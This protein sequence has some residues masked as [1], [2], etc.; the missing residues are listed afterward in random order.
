MKLRTPSLRRFGVLFAAAGLLLLA[1][2]TARGALEKGRERPVGPGVKTYSLIDKEK[3]LA[4]YVVE[5]DLSDP[6][7]SLEVGLSHDRLTRNE[8]VPSM[9]KRLTKA[10]HRVIAAVNGDFWARAGVAT[11]MLVQNGQL[12]R[13]PGARSV[14][15]LTLDKRPIIDYFETR[16]S[17]IGTQGNALAV[18]QLNGW[19]EGNETILFTSNRVE[20]VT[21]PLG[22]YGVLLAPEVWELQPDDKL[23]A[24]VV[25]LVDPGEKMDLKET[26]FALIVP[27]EKLVS[28]PEGMVLGDSVVLE[29]DTHGRIYGDLPGPLQAVAGGPRL[30]L[31][32]K[33]VVDE[34]G[35]MRDSFNQTRH[36]R[37]AL[38]I[39]QDEKTL[40][41]VVVDGRQT[42]HSIGID[43]YDLA[44]FLKG[45]GSYQAMNLDGGGSSTMVVRDEIA[46]RPS[47]SAGPRPVTNC[48]M[49]VSNAPE[50][51]LRRLLIEPPQ[52]E[53]F[54][55]QTLQLTLSAYDEFYN[56][57]EI[58]EDIIH[59]SVAGG[60]AEIDR[61]GRLKAGKK[62]G[63]VTVVVSVEGQI[64]TNLNFVTT[65]AQGR[66]AHPQQLRL[67]PEQIRLS[68]GEATQLQVEALSLG[69]Q[70]LPAPTDSLRWR[71]KNRKIGTL[72]RQGRFIA[73]TEGQGEIQVRFS[74]LRATIPVLVGQKRTELLEDFSSVDDWWLTGTNVSIDQ[75]RIQVSSEQVA[76]GTRS[77][78][79]DYDLRHAGGTSAVYLN[80]DKPMPWTPEQIDFWLYGNDCDHLFRMVLKDVDGEKFYADA[81]GA[82][83]WSGEWKK[84]EIPFSKFLPLWSNPAAKLTAPFYLEQLYIVEPRTAEKS[85][86][87]IYIDDLTAVYPPQWD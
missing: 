71:L 6:H 68:P 59:W 5:V 20:S 58:P 24:T 66:I 15:A 74:G 81:P 25:R 70:W 48:L 1:A 50:G 7:L 19:A 17:V 79:L 60:K 82:I 54:P 43:L 2:P 8:T 87:T 56:P 49:V 44:E 28:M 14:F 55:Q 72:T 52:F 46:N 83:N 41:L 84:I 47:D 78:R 65:R 61:Q 37:T 57:V 26:D 62:P 77:L 53:L 22:N 45:L 33:E 16:I 67:A 34:V 51:S 76:A 18:D 35:E 73:A 10:N 38:G 80:T 4:A 40:Y 31:D 9:A 75:S 69:N 13:S 27:K 64:G 12:Y 30:L 23:K 63:E 42:G 32:G 29:I 11:G 86:G 39:S 36:P 85:Q 3:P 21:P